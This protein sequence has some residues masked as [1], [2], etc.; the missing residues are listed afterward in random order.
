MAK[1]SSQRFPARTFRL[2]NSSPEDRRPWQLRADGTLSVL[3]GAEQRERLQGTW[4]VDYRGRY[5]RSLNDTSNVPETCFDVVVNDAEFNFFDADGLMRF[6][7]TE[8]WGLVYYGAVSH[9]VTFCSKLKVERRKR[10]EDKLR[11]H[12]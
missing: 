5:C 2:E 7:T 4:R 3:A 1:H 11:E 10:D 6:D 8:K 9:M 12:V